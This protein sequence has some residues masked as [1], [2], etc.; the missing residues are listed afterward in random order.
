MKKKLGIIVGIVSVVVV[1]SAGIF[2]LYINGLPPVEKQVPLP[3]S[4]LL[5]W[6]TA[7]D[8]GAVLP[9]NVYTA[10]TAVAEGLQPVKILELYVDGVPVG[11]LNQQQGKT[12]TILRARWDWLPASAGTHTLL[13]RASDT[14]GNISESEVLTITA[15]EEANLTG[16][17]HYLVQKSD[18]LASLEQQYG[19][20]QEQIMEF[21]PG[22]DP[23][24][25]LAE[26]QWLKFPAVLEPIKS[27]KASEGESSGTQSDG[28]VPKS[29]A[30][31]GSEGIALPTLP[32]DGIPVSGEL[33]PDVGLVNPP[34]FDPGIAS[35][36]M[37][38]TL[39]K[40]TFWADATLGDGFR[41]PGDLNPFPPGVEG[42]VEACNAVLKIQSRGGGDTAA[43]FVYR[44]DPFSSKFLRIASLPPISGSTTLRYADTGLFGEYQYYV[45]SLVGGKELPGKVITIKITEPR[46]QTYD[47]LGIVIKKATLT[48]TAAVDGVFIYFSV[49]EAGWMRKPDSP[50]VYMVTGSA[51]SYDFTPYLPGLAIAPKLKLDMR[52]YGYLGGSAVKLGSDATFTLDTSKLPPTVVLKGDPCTLTLT[53]V[54][55]TPPAP[56]LNSKLTPPFMLRSTNN[57]TE[58]RNHLPPAWAKAG[59]EIVI[60]ING[61]INE[62]PVLIWDWN[63]ACKTGST[64][65]FD[66]AIAG[67]HLYR[68]RPGNKNV[69]V[70]TKD[71]DF[72]VDTFPRPSL[73]I[74]VA[75]GP[76]T[77]YVVR[78][79]NKK[80]EESAN[81]NVFCLSHLE[82]G[83]A[84][85][86]LSPSLATY[87]WKH[88]RSAVIGIC[89]IDSGGLAG[90]DFGLAGDE[91]VAG[92]DHYYEGGICWKQDNTWYRGIFQFDLKAIPGTPRTLNLSYNIAA[93][94]CFDSLNI[95]PDPSDMG[96]YKRITLMGLSYLGKLAGPDTQYLSS[97][98]LDYAKDG[99]KK[100]TFLLIG[101]DEDLD[102]E[103]N[104][105][106]VG[107]LSQ[108]RL[109]ISYLKY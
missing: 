79:Y 1:A 40:L 42:S 31:P 107:K 48:T 38:L 7:P 78:S 86:E 104:D 62:N 35:E 32:K 24:A 92:W 50:V 106:C 99:P 68:L 101:K 105:Y 43:F 47:N 22:L 49:N 30:V 52:C 11:V 13:V 46:C 77:C 94:S 98:L 60:C 55:G 15:S 27:S 39:D 70:A 56:P 18:T 108:L 37:D 83:L 74:L 95:V 8:N 71:Y 87:T 64:C 44:L 76:D 85:A 66:D 97:S 81:S 63:P 57:V 25:P 2:A 51:G 12:D 90:E 109:N 80:G 88:H 36:P 100:L 41:I 61:I 65:L 102:A 73:E 84:H 67:Y 75:D 59:Y 58:C 5:V 82:T 29:T 91:T 45:S 26:G 17:R 9:L 96:T 14:D 103:N 10:I 69:L 33:P 4:R 93:G 72:K 21:N 16:A 3:E 34:P 28:P 54:K 23:L 6:L 19:L 20:T 53:I 89:G